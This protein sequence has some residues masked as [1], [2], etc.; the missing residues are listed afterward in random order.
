M[1]VKEFNQKIKELGISEDSEMVVHAFGG[2]RS[3][4]PIRDI[5]RGF[6]WDMGSVVLHPSIVLTIYKDQK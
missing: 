3:G 4:K 1:T 2:M 6:D 5:T